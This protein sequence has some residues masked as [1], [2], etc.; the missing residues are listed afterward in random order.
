MA[1]LNYP[2]TENIETELANREIASLIEALT[3][4]LTPKQKMVFVL[5]E[6]EELTPAEITE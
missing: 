1:I 6:L 2:S 5:S 4:Q 3:G